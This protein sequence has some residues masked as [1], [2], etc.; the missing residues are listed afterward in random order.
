MLTGGRS[1]QK[2]RARGAG[3]DLTWP[4]LTGML[5]FAWAVARVG[6]YGEGSA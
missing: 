1:T 2:R 3:S 6:Q 4:P 5:A